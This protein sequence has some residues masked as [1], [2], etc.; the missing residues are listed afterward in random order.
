M[1]RRAEKILRLAMTA[2]A[3]SSGSA[4]AEREPAE[5]RVGLLAVIG[6]GFEETSGRPSIRGAELAVRRINDGG[7]FIVDDRVY[8]VRVVV[9]TYPNRP[10]AAARTARLLLN[11]DSVHV[12]VG[13]QL[14]HHAIPVSVIA[15]SAGVPMISPMSSNPETTAGKRFVFRLAFLDDAQATA[16]GEF[17]SGELK[18]RRAA[19]LYDESNPYGPSLARRF[20]KAFESAGGAVV[21]EETYTTDRNKTFY[22]QLA[23]IA[24]TR[25][26]V[27]LL[28]NPAWEDSIQVV[29]ARQLGI[30]A[31]F[32]GSDRWDLNMLGDLAEAQGAIVSHQWHHEGTHAESIDFIRAFRDEFGIGPHTTAAMT[33]DAVG[34]LAAA[35]EKAG[36]LEPSQIALAIERLIGYRGATGS[37]TF[38]GRHDPE[39]SVAISTIRDGGVAVLRL[40]DPPAR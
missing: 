22:D 16:L 27:L 23:R 36:T 7:G 3:L 5:L 30:D 40:W 1:R 8:R 4:C 18:A 6:D 9:R 2:A 14:S 19:L 11:E 20:S 39:R 26:D 13:P 21:A 24:L 37:I 17:A 31:V 38:A 34:V 12:L 25:P 35:V 15:E 29:Q 33:Y 10:D 32:L 28:P